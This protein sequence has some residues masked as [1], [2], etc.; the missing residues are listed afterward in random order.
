MNNNE[1]SKGDISPIEKAVYNFVGGYRT[2]KFFDM[3]TA[4]GAGICSV[5]SMIAISNYAAT[6]N[7]P[8]FYIAIGAAALQATLSLSRI[9]YDIVHCNDFYRNF[10]DLAETVNKFRGNC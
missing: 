7:K 9:A 2:E 10:S 3:T 6:Q 8:A 4:I 5:T 1:E